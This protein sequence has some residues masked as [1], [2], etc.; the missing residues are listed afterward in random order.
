MNIKETLSGIVQSAELPDEDRKTLTD[1]LEQSEPVSGHDELLKTIEQL[2]AERDCA[3]K[4]LD[5]MIFK[6][7]VAELADSYSFSDKGYLEYLCK[8]NN[9][10]LD[11]HDSSRNFMLKLQN[12]TPKFFKLK[13]Q[14]GTGVPADTGDCSHLK[15][16]YQQND[17]LSLLNN[18]PEIRG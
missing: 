7:H 1:W 6:N 12:D 13:L 3:Q 2:Q 9:V 18:A 16:D 10:D 14:S 5:D 17:I 8:I 15:K 4:S 11:D